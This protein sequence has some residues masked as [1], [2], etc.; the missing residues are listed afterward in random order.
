MV[1][2]KAIKSK[3]FSSFFLLENLLLFC[4]FVRS[5]YKNVTFEEIKISSKNVL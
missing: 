2:L 3:Q 5:G 4:F 1:I